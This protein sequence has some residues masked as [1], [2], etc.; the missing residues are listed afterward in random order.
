MDSGNLKLERTLEI[1]C[2]RKLRSQEGNK[3][4]HGQTFGH[5]KAKGLLQ[6]LLF[7]LPMRLAVGIPI[8]LGGHRLNS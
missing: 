4:A 8:R 7:D 6:Q 5:R 2:V 1:L 3:H